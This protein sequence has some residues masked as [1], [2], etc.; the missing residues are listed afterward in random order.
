M[1][2]ALENVQTNITWDR[3]LELAQLGLSAD[4]NSIEQFRV[5]VDGTFESGIRMASG[6]FVPVLRRTPSC[7]M[8]SFTIPTPPLPRIRPRPPKPPR[9]NKLPSK[10]PPYG[11]FFCIWI[12]KP[13]LTSDVS[14][15]RHKRKAAHLCDAPPFFTQPDLFVLSSVAHEPSASSHAECKY[16]SVSKPERRQSKRPQLRCLR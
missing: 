7:S 4:L 2:T 11:G 14:K 1:T 5:P 8:I 3:L 6:A 15:R 16:Y 9:L 12:F 10:K 13:T